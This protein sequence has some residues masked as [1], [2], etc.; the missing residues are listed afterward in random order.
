MKPHRCREPDSGHDRGSR[1]LFFKI[2]MIFW[3]AIF[4]TIASNAL[5]THQIAQIEL[6]KKIKETRISE[7]AA[8]AV[9]VYETGGMSALE[10]WLHRQKR[11]LGLRAALHDAQ[12]RRIEPAT[13]PEL[14]HTRDHDRITEED[15]EPRPWQ[16]WS[17]RN[18]SHPAK[19]IDIPVTSAQGQDYHFILLPSRFTRALF[20]APEYYRWIRFLVSFIIIATA[21]WLLS[22]H[23]GRPIKALSRASRKMA[24]GDLSVR[25]LPEIGARKDELGDMAE[26]FDHMAEQVEH[27]VTQQQ[28]LFRDIS[29]E[30]RTPLTR[31]QLQI[32]LA[33]RKGLSEETLDK[34]AA[35]NDAMNQ[36]IE[37]VLT[38]SKATLTPS[39]SAPEVFDISTL[40]AEIIQQNRAEIESKQ[41]HLNAALNV[42][43]TVRAERESLQRGLENL[44]RN[45]IKFSPEGSGI[46]V[47]TA[48]QTGHVKISIT[49]EGPGL[50]GERPENLIQPFKRGA[51][52]NGAKG[53]GIGLAIAHQAIAQAGGTL[54]FEEAPASGL[55][56]TIT[57]PLY[58]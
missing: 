38:L 23:L 33:R 18:F 2:L 52:P 17:P 58:R 35:Q 28:Q 4:L 37:Q 3:G 42:T 48:L 5:L 41:Q 27:L 54:G 10:H 43:A 11:L 24:E 8:D 9:S 21:S 31:Q 30:L 16:R 7:L 45:A 29:H 13:P 14:D 12:G 50:Q 25:V 56:V 44:L 1:R 46:Q 55:T 6:E 57:L 49:D 19:P 53:F 34:L 36:L 32:E 20:S 47:G 40:V 15:K 51:N 22:R 26:D 39:K